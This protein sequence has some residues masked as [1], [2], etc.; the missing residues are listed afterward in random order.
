M[1]AIEKGDR[2]LKPGEL[3][4]L[5][6]AYG[7]SVSDFVRPR[8]F[9]EPFDTQFQ[10]MYRLNKEEEQEIKPYVLQLEELCQNYLELE[11]IMKS[12]LPRKYPPEY[13]VSGMPVEVTAG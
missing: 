4:K 8:S 6:R 2:R 10:A 9:V 12:P 13:N 7:K 11:Q 1:V 3:I 5:A